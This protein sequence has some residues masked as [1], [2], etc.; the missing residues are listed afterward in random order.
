MTQ[1][2]HDNIDFRQIVVLVEG[3]EPITAACTQGRHSYCHS[4]ED[5]FGLTCQERCC[6]T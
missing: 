2:H 1:Y 3:F 6:K 5:V 4:A